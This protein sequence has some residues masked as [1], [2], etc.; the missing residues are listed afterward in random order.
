MRLLVLAVCCTI[1]FVLYERALQ[2]RQFLLAGVGLSAAVFLSIA[3]PAMLAQE[4]P[5]AAKAEYLEKWSKVRFSQRPNVYLISFDSMI[6]TPLAD[7]LLGVPELA[8]VR[9]LQKIDTQIV[10]N[11]FVAK[12]GSWNVLNAL[13]TLDDSENFPSD[14][15]LNGERAG[16]L[17][18]VFRA[19]GY[20]TAAGFGGI[21][22]GLHGKYL[23]RYD[24]IAGLNT[25]RISLCKFQAQLVLGLQVGHFGFCEVVRLFDQSYVTGSQMWP[26]FVEAVIT[27]PNRMEPWLTLHY[28]YSP[29]GHT[30]ADYRTGDEAQFTDYRKAFIKGANDVGHIVVSMIERIRKTDPQ[31]IIFVF[32]DHGTWLSRTIGFDDNPNFFVQDRYGVF[33]GFPKTGNPCS[34]PNLSI[35]A[36]GYHTVGR[37][38]ASIVRCLAETPREVDALVNFADEHDF[39]QYRYEAM[40]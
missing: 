14:G 2:S 20:K 3:G 7:K 15:Y 10:R 35:Y 4:P 6:P 32:G 28:I 24:Y 8:Y 29:I 25:Y 26:S 40:P 9:E 5:G 22:F 1:F 36:N 34:S 11:T 39:S 13:V 23:D 37:A 38:V 19:N 27:D 30:S 31:G 16:P 17:F 33:A 21:Y 12:Q 18:E